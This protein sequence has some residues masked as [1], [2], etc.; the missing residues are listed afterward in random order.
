M[1]I[2]INFLIEYQ[3]NAQDVTLKV[4]RTGRE[5]CKPDKKDVAWTG[6]HYSLHFIREGKGS[7]KMGEN[8]IPLKEGMCFVLYKDT[9]CEYYP[10][11][12]RPWKYDWIDFSGENL[13]ILL[14]ECGFSREKPYRA[15]RTDNYF[16]GELNRLYEIHDVKPYNHICV[17]AQFFKL[18]SELIYR[19]K[20]TKP[21]Q[22]TVTAR[23]F[24]VR[25]SIVYINCNFRLDLSMADI[26]RANSISVSYLS[27]S[28]SKEIGMSPLEYMHAMRISEACRYLKNSNQKIKD[29]AQ[30]V[31]YVDEKYFSRVFKKYKGLSPMQYRK[32]S[33]ETDPFLW[34]KEK[35]LDFR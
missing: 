28:W 31:G 26:A 27:S 18:L 15:Y 19:N 29:I 25:D 14:S 6:S 24:R 1:Q 17:A 8:E 7:I 3:G 11:K 9:P 32:T 21:P 35:N 34:L 10:D 33:D 12:S 5:S 2:S 30:N 4:K 23:Y 13:D 16:L 20:E 22:N